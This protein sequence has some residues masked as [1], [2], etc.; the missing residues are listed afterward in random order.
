MTFYQNNT[1]LFVFY[2]CILLTE[3]KVKS[4][5]RLC[6]S[7]EKKTTSNITKIVSLKVNHNKGIEVNIIICTKPNFYLYPR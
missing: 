2:V 5:D 7:C 1:R 4:I 6:R 3:N